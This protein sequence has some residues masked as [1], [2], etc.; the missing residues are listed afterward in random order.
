M[1]D[2]RDECSKY[3]SVM[4]VEIPRPVGGV[5]VPGCGKVWICASWLGISDVVF[6]R[7]YKSKKHGYPLCYH[8]SVTITLCFMKAPGKEKGSKN[9]FFSSFL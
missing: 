4:G 1:E 8:Y 2:V 3:G 9:D 5:E 7:M 6:Q